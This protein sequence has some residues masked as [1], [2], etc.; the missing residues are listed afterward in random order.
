MSAVLE[1]PTAP[2]AREPEPARVSPPRRRRPEW[3]WAAAVV[4]AALVVLAIALVLASGGSKSPPR[5]RTVAAI[6]RG[7]TPADEARNLGAWLR[8]Y[9]R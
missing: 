7:S 1:A 4:V 6:P 5:K 9:S 8:K 3:L 2:L